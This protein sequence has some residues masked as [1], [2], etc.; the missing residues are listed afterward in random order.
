MTDRLTPAN[1]R[2]LLP[3]RVLHDHEVRG[4]QLVA[5]EAAKSWLVYYRTKDGRQKRP[6]IGH[7]PSLNIDAARRAARE[8]LEQVAAGKDPAGDWNARRREPSVWDLWLDY[9]GHISQGGRRK[10]STC[11]EYHRQMTKLLLPHPLSA[12]RVS[13]VTLA[14]VEA[15]VEDVRSRKMYGNRDRLARPSQARAPHAGNRALSTLSGAFR[16]AV[17]RL[18]WLDRNP[19][20]HGERV[21]ERRRKRYATA[22][23]LA[24]LGAYLRERWPVEPRAVALVI[25][26]LYTGARTSEMAKA[27]WTS[28]SADW[29]TLTLTEHKTS[30]YHGDKQIDIPPALMPVLKH[31]SALASNRGPNTS[32][33]I[34]GDLPEGPCRALWERARTKAGCPDLQIRDLRRTFA[35]LGYNTDQDARILQD[36]LGHENPET[37]RIYTQLFS[38][39]RK[40]A[41]TA[42]ADKAAGLLAARYPA[43]VS[44]PPTFRRV[45]RISLTRSEDRPPRR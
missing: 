32:L 34:F 3:G 20:S 27:K 42:I 7:F 36:L 11:R 19:C 16:H 35:S 2:A 9:H 31:L 13:D 41:T 25:A 38:E 33:F 24:A 4:L 6:T 39:A 22:T 43:A 17:V 40:N 1:A 29:S 18:R 26:L 37:T 5:Y 44:R 30:R 10:A 23:E 12:K 8:I 45:R 28:L 21:P 14:D 15:W